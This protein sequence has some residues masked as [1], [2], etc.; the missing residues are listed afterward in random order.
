MLLCLVLHSTELLF[1]YVSG[2]TWLQ[3]LPLSHPPWNLKSE[4]LHVT[5]TE[6][7]PP[8]VTVYLSRVKTKTDDDTVANRIR[9][10]DF[11]FVPVLRYPTSLC[12]I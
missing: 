2:L 10:L 12:Y 11:C 8:S 9:L 7:L 1:S 4:Q 5:A 6:I 3:K